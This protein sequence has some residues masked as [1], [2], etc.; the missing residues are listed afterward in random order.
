MENQQPEE[1]LV[2]ANVVEADGKLLR[3][4]ISISL[5]LHILNALSIQK[6]LNLNYPSL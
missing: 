2:K 3:N 4:L 1:I 6:S 5:V